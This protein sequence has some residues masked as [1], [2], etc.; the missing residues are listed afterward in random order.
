M[1]KTGF[2]KWI[3]YLAVQITGLFCG[4]GM[5]MATMV[6]KNTVFWVWIEGLFSLVIGHLLYKQTERWYKTQKIIHQGVFPEEIK[7]AE[8]LF[9]SM[10]TAIM[11]AGVNVFSVVGLIIVLK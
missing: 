8:P 7:P 2:G 10:I 9:V 3:L 5:M 11:L 1:K 6:V 4:V